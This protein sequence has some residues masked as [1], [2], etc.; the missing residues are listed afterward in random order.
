MLF[1]LSLRVFIV[2]FLVLSTL[3]VAV[4]FLPMLY[5]KLFPPRDIHAIVNAL[6]GQNEAPPGPATT[7]VEQTRA[8]AGVLRRAVQVGYHTEVSITVRYNESR[9]NRKTQVSYIAWFD[10]FPNPML[11]LITR[12][13]TAGILQGYEI[14][15]GAPMSLVGSY[16][17]PLLIFVFSL[18]LFLKRRSSVFKDD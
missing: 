5:S 15:E 11:L 16:A 1:R 2:G 3:W 8:Q 7:V 6:E 4:A 14:N 9:S 13:E 12:S 18:F 10:K 17:L